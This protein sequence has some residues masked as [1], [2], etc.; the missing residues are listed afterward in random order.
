MSLRNSSLQPLASL[1]TGHSSIRPQVAPAGIGGSQVNRNGLNIYKNA[2]MRYVVAALLTNVLRESSRAESYGESFSITKKLRSLSYIKRAWA[3]R[4]SDVNMESVVLPFLLLCGEK[5]EKLENDTKNC[6][7]RSAI[8]FVNYI[9]KVAIP[10]RWRYSLVSRDKVFC[11][12]YISVKCL[13]VLVV[14]VTIATLAEPTSAQNCTPLGGYP[15]SQGACL[16]SSDLN[17]ALEMSIS[18][19]PP[20]NAYGQGAHKGKLWLD[21]SVSP[22]MVRMCVIAAP[23]SCNTYYVA[24]E[25]INW[26]PVN[27]NAGQVNW[28]LGGGIATV[29]SSAVVDLGL[30]P[31]T[32]LSITGTAQIE[33]FGLTLPAGQSKI[34]IFQGA[35]T[36]TYSATAIAI[37]TGADLATHAGGMAIVTAQGNGVYSLL[38][39]PQASGGGGGGTVNSGAGPA[40]AQ[41]LA[42][43]GTTLVPATVS[44]DG[45]L[46]QGGALTLA[47]SGVVPGPYTNTSVTFDAKGRATAAS[48]GSTPLLA[49]NNLSDGTPAT[50]RTNLGLGTLATQNATALNVTGVTLLTGLPAPVNP[51]DAARLTDVQA[52]ASGIT[53]H[54]SVVAATAAALAA[55]TYDNAA[56]TITMTSVGVT[57]IDGYTPVLNDRVLIRNE[58]TASHNGIYTLTTVGTGTVAAVFTRAPDFNTAAP[59]NIAYGATV[60][61]GGSGAVNH[62]VTFFMNTTGTITVGTTSINWVIFITPGAGVTGPGSS[63][64]GCFPAWNGAAGNTLSTGLCGAATSTANVLVET[65][66]GGTINS[67]FLATNSIT[68]ALAAQMAANTIKGNNT[69]SLANA[70]DLTAGQVTAMLNPVVGD[71]GSGGTKGLVPAPAA[72]DAAAG[73]YLGAS[74]GYSVP[75]AAPIANNTVLGNV[76]GGNAVPGQLS[77]AQLTA[78][79][80]SFTSLVKGCLPPGGGNQYSYPGGDAA[81][82][83]LPSI[84]AANAAGVAALAGYS[85]GQAA[86]RTDV[87]A[88]YTFSNTNCT[89]NG[90]GGDNGSQIK[91]SSGGGCWNIAPQTIYD[92]RIWGANAGASDNAVAIGA[93]LSAVS[94][95]YAGGGQYIVG[96][97]LTMPVGASLLCGYTIPD[98]EQTPAAFGSAPAIKLAGTATITVGAA[99]AIRG[100]LIYRNGMTFPAPDASAFAGTAVSDGG[101]ENVSIVDSVI[102]GFGTCIKITGQRPYVVHDNVD[103][104][105]SAGAIDVENGNTDSGYFNQLKLQPLATGNGSC[106]ASVR[107]GVGLNMNGINFF[108]Q[109]VSQNF[110]KNYLVTAIVLAGNIWSDSIDEVCGRASIG[111]DVETGGAFDPATSI[112]LFGTKTGAIFNDGGGTSGGTFGF[113]IGYVFAGNLG[114]G[115]CLD[116]QQNGPINIGSFQT[117]GPGISECGGYG[118]NITNGTNSITIQRAEISGVHGQVAPYINATVP[119]NIAGGILNSNLSI[120]NLVTPDLPLGTNPYDTIHFVVGNGSAPALA[121]IYAL[122]TSCS[123][124]GTGGS[125][126]LIPGSTLVSGGVT[127]TAG[128]GAGANGAAQISLVFTPLNGRS[129]GW[130]PDDGTGSWSALAPITATTTG[131]IGPTLIL[132]W[133]VTTPLTSGKTYNM[134]YSC[135]SF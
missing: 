2:R 129:C 95:C 16:Q 112:N 77:Q 97:N 82:H 85:S 72:G 73:K 45:A 115:D 50:M 103:C 6:L 59:G 33:S 32:L 101:N 127:I 116:F 25:W 35:L 41:Y 113:H 122:Y 18:P 96:S 114:S 43:T 102:M 9:D 1:L 70:L 124:A 23:N 10:L 8:R 53:P 99:G 61:A 92:I 51:S 66:A 125:C 14:G 40:I 134:L 57:T 38:Y 106:T 65:G 68:N 52:A 46:A 7:I 71:S 84:T 118:I 67:N 107:T 3:Q 49:A 15:F 109:I 64:N 22:A 48:S 132:N 42:G 120:D 78:L 54:T 31:Q 123:G 126:A 60:Q 62:N 104:Q 74:G 39:Q 55:N 100:C 5:T 128:T 21:L 131:E 58:S 17:N 91:P 20:Q 13:F 105:S 36:I 119:I 80:N 47:A 81:W 12:Y 93:C 24:N 28:P 89:L 69:G 86:R 27:F 83:T 108:D 88:L 11:S 133:F 111:V 90:G 29:P 110:M 63:I 121:S 75:T 76:S 79:C 130:T 56:A 26:M 19:S 44:G 87:D 117:G 135:G 94:S 37:P 98:L 30:Y 34:L 4:R